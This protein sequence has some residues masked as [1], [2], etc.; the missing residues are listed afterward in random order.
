MCPPVF[1]SSNGCVAFASSVPNDV[2]GLIYT[3]R[4]DG[5]IM[6]SLAN[7]RPTLYK[8]LSIL[9]VGT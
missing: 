1:I 4:V 7:N 5:I 3:R 8:V 6:I 9:D 2:F